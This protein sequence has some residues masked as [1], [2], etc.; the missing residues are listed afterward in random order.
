MNR[1]KAFHDNKLVLAPEPGSFTAE[2]E[3]TRWSNKDLDPVPPSR[4][5]WEW[6]HVGGFWIAEG[7]NVAQFQTISSAVALGL[8]PGIALVACLIG[9]LMVTVPVCIMGYVGAKVQL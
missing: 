5:K 9:N 2:G 7:F 6:Y 8:N 4:K 3:S 1:I